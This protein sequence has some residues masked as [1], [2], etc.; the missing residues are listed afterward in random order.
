MPRLHLARSERQLH[1]EATRHELGVP[2][3][4]LP[5]ARERAHLALHLANQVVDAR[6]VERR[7]LEPP[8]GAAASVAIEANPSRFLEEL[9]TVVG[10]VREQRVDRLG[11]R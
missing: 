7:L 9:T 4:T 6:Q 5:L 1:R 8:F 10:A 11:S 2:L 3:C